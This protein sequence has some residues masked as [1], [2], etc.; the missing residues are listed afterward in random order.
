MNA[1]WLEGG[2]PVCSGPKYALEFEEFISVVG[3][4]TKDVGAGHNQED[5]YSSNSIRLRRFPQPLFSN[6]NLCAME[7]M[8]KKK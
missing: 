7:L 8:L 3:P 4:L 2:K 1:V 6:Q 5:F